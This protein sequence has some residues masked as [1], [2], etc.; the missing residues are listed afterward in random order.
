[1]MIKIITVA[2]TGVA[3]FVGIVAMSGSAD[4]RAGHRASHSHGHHMFITGRHHMARCVW[5]HG[6]HHHHGIK[7]RFCR[8]FYW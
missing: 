6:W 3:L 1:M 8:P 7:V 5:R 2:A 4:A